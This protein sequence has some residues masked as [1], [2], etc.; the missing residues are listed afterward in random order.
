M[1]PMGIAIAVVVVLRVMSMVA[2][3]ASTNV[4][5]I[6][7]VLGLAIVAA[8]GSG[9]EYCRT[10]PGRRSSCADAALDQPWPGQHHED[11]AG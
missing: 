3:V 7:P 5:D 8:L 2:G 1:L 6:V 4:V 9:R 11:D 10:A